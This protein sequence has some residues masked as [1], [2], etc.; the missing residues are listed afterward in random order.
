MLR[1]QK[2]EDLSADEKRARM[3]SMRSQVKET[4]VELDI[5]GRW[6]TKE[7]WEHKVKRR[8]K[9]IKTEVF[10]ENCE[11]LCAYLKLGR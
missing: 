6:V 1:N 2:D 9:W 11:I 4:I 8:K 3:K 10:I 7:K 5:R